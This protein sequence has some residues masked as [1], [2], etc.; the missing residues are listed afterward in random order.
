M[1]QA[2]L[3]TVRL[4]EGR[5]H[6][7]DGWPPA[8]SR[9]F[10]A[11]M[12]GAA[13]GACVPQATLDALDWLENLP[14]PE[15]AAPRDVPGQTYKSYVPNNDLDAALP[16]K[17]N[18]FDI[19][20]AIA[21]VRAPKLMKPILFDVDTPIIYCWLINGEAA[22][23]KALC[24]A[25]ENL[26]QLGRGV[27]MAWAEAAVVGADDAARR[28][29]D[30]GGIIF[31]PSLGG[32][33]NLK[34]LCPRPGSRRSLTARFD[35]MRHRFRAGETKRRPVRVFVQPPKPLFAKIAYDA[36]PVRL[37]FELRD[38]DVKSGFA[39]RRLSDIAQ[40]TAEVR[41]QVAKR[42]VNAVPSHEADIERYLV[43]RDAKETD[44]A[45]RVQ[46]VPIPS[47][48]HPY[49][50]MMIRR[51]VVYVPQS[52]PLPSGDLAWAF[53]QV[54]WTDDDGVIVGEL[55]RA[56]DD[57]MVNRYERRGRYWK[58]VTPLALSTARRRRIDL[59]R[60]SD[61]AKDGAERM[62]EEMRAV[63]AVRQALRHAGVSSTPTDVRV[64]REPFETR[65][66][67]V[68][69]FAT[70][71]RFPKN[72]LWHVAISFAAPV[73]GPL[74][75]GDGRY[76]GLGLMRPHDPVPGVLVFTIQEEGLL[77]AAEPQ[78]VAHAARRAMMAR[79]RNIL[80]R[81]QLL[82]PYVTGHEK[83]SSPARSGLHQHIAIA[84]DLPRKRILYIAPN[85][86]QR[87]GVKW[88]DVRKDHELVERALEGM[89]TL[90]AGK[91]GRLIIAPS[92]LD[93][94]H[95]PLFAPAQA[96]ESVTDYQVTRHRRR[97]TDEEAL[98]A[99][100][101]AELRRRGWPV[102]EAVE[103]LAAH[104]GPRGALSG[105]LRIAFATAQP[106]PLL[107]GQ[108]A[109]KGGGLFASST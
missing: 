46:I 4:H 43:G 69:P 21:S 63:H 99:D 68:E 54:V 12:A 93:T 42:L 25:A 98:R 22:L 58:S 80:Q 6:G 65:G 74:S 2:L 17:K 77:D 109:H 48:G 95:D 82:P 73:T 67:R 91:A 60:S 81:G 49:A 61:E 40:L 59:A 24:E 96:W 19:D 8:P 11:L 78:L 56:S 103:I 97:L 41:D 107:L 28:L 45:A 75:L 62:R 100:M 102:P 85:R 108:T 47:V 53:A 89:D 90:L 37:V 55:Q 44:K 72:A 23:A 71:T 35:G 15:I 31:R 5:Y 34:L 106:G 83:D 32:E 38:R 64:Q 3:V 13:R 92:A 51:L 18:A 16:E 105:R 10:Q 70:G 52:C 29:S 86:L 66:E 20:K 7:A 104:R 14:H 88:G 26:Y 33:S 76:L 36:P 39:A 84:A 101:L 50:D 1:K 27:D 79:V 57:G 30:H 94:E 87:H 9:L